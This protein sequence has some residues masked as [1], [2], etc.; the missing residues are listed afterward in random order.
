MKE[1][2]ELVSKDKSVKLELAEESL[3][4]LS[5]LLNER[6]LSE[7]AKNA[8]KAAT[9]KIAEAHGFTPAR[10]EEL[11]NEELEAVAGGVCRDMVSI[12]PGKDCPTM[13]HVSP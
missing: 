9:Q 6:G 7:D 10:K 13:L 3:K 1:F 12:I 11:S 4:A 8:M 5:A 2:F